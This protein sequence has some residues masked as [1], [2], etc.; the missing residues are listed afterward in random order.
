MRAALEGR[1]MRDFPV[2]GNDRIVWA[3]IDKETGLLASGEGE[4]TIF[5]SFI[6]GSE[7]TETADAAR[8]TDR[9]EQDLREENFPDG[10]AAAPAVDPDL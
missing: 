5:Q 6:A 9:A 3:R 2:P 8:E 4:G 7:P 1:P 10:E